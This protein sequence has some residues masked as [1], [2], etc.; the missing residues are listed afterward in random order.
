MAQEE[1]AWMKGSQEIRGRSLDNPIPQPY[2]QT[3]STASQ[4]RLFLSWVDKELIILQGKITVRLENLSLRRHS[5]LLP[6]PF[7]MSIPFSTLLTTFCLLLASK[8]CLYM[9]PSDSPSPVCSIS[10]TNWL[11]Y[12]KKFVYFRFLL[13]ACRLVKDD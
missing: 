5:D 10:P 1:A 12:K 8:Y 2:T 11:H 13:S 6:C 3:I 7:R 4:V 9:F